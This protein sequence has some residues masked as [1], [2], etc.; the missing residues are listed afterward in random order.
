VH[1]TIVIILLTAALLGC[2]GGS[3]SSTLPPANLPSGGSTSSPVAAPSVV[4]VTAGQAASGVNIS[5]PAPSGTQP[6]ATALG[7]AGLT[8]SASA[9]NTGGVIG[10]GTTMRVVMFGPGLAGDMRV[11]I[12]GPD[13]IQISNVTG[14][15][16][17][18]KTPGIS[19]T[20]TVAGNAGLGAR[21]VVLQTASGNMTAFTGGLEVVP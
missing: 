18:D 7:V 10:R 16:A 3:S 8:G 4:Q 20:A 2:G 15:T 17:T 19:F 12:L 21:T 11:T 5:V 9:F 14:I 13:D 6:N 1:K